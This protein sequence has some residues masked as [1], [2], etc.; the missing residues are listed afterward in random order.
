MELERAIRMP[1]DDPNWLV[2]ILIGGALTLIPIINL[3]SHGYALE[4]MRRSINGCPEMPEWDDWG[5]KFVKGLVALLVS[6]IYCIP[7]LIIMGAGGG[8]GA[9]MNGG[10]GT[11][12][13]FATGYAIGFILLLFIGFVIPMALAHY[14]ATG[15]VGSAFAL[16]AV[17]GRIRE[18]LS[19]YAVAYVMAVVM[20]L[21]VGLVGKL[22]IIGWLLGA[23]LYFYVLIVIAVL[24]GAVYSRTVDS[25]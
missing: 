22:P 24:F 19:D 6:L 18:R 12:L 4:A 3:L 7:L 16:G 15:S 20:L 14:I 25:V 17:L 5:D 21:L 8:L 9:L 11:G 23:F 13:F 10:M 1:L 2:K